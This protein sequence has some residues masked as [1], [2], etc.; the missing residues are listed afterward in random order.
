MWKSFSF[1]IIIFFSF[2]SIL[3]ELNIIIKFEIIYPTKKVTQVKVKFEKIVEANGM[4]ALM[5]DWRRPKHNFKNPKS[6]LIDLGFE[7][8]LLKHLLSQLKRV[9]TQTN[10]LIKQIYKDFLEFY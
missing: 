3:W 6:H 7:N 2:L 8:D 1:V 9:V 5:L 4:D 10:F